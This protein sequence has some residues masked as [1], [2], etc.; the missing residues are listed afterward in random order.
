MCVKHSPQPGGF[1]SAYNSERSKA[2]G[3]ANHTPVH[4]HD[5]VI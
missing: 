1:F 4:L 2:V 3:V 5:D